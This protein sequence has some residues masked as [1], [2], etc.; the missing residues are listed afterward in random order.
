MPPV[1][2]ERRH[3]LIRAGHAA[4][5]LKALGREP[6]VQRFS[7]VLVGSDRQT[8]RSIEYPDSLL[9]DMLA[10]LEEAQPGIRGRVL[11]KRSQWVAAGLP[12]EWEAVARAILLRHLNAA[13][14]ELWAALQSAEEAG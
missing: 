4:A 8:L 5:E 12:G 6:V 1:S 10:G 2:D 3:Q 7:L 14:D 11:D 9:G 13:V